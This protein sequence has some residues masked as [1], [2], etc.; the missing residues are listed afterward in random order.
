MQLIINGVAGANATAYSTSPGTVAQ[1]QLG[2][3]ATGIPDA[4]DSADADSANCYGDFI[5]VKSGAAHE[6]GTAIVVDHK[7]VTSALPATA[8]TGQPF[9]IAA[10]RFTAADEFGW[11]QLYGQAPVLMSEAVD[12]ADPLFVT[13]AG[14]LGDT[15]AAGLQ[16][17]GVLCKIGSAGA[18]TKASSVTRNGSTFVQLTN[19]T[20]LY[21]GIA[22]SGTGI[23][24]STEITSIDPG[25]NSIVINNA[26]T[27]SGSVTLTFTHTLYGICNL[28]YPHVQGQDAT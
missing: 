20:G 15:A 11:M 12:A 8:G 18:T 28:A 24:A 27:A 1:F 26:A 23:A 16:A 25:N 21:A 22:V 10:T 9:G 6:V 3:K 5:Y 14:T 4:I 2:T 7:L 13:G 17:L 19:T